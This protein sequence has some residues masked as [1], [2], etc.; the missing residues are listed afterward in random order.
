MK[1]LQFAVAGILLAGCTPEEFHAADLPR[2][3]P[4]RVKKLE[5]GK[6]PWIVDGKALLPIVRKGKPKDDNWVYW[7]RFTINSAGWLRSA[8]KE[9]TGVEPPLVRVADGEPLPEGPALFIGDEFAKAAGIE[10]PDRKQHEFRVVSKNGSIYFCGREDYAVYDFGER[11]LGIRQYW[12]TADGGRSVLKTPTI[13]LPELDYSDAPVY[14]KRDFWPYEYK[15]DWF[16]V[17]KG[18]NCHRPVFHCH[19]PHAWHTDTNFNYKVTRPEIFELTRDGR[20]AASPMLCYSNTKTFETYIERMEMELAGGPKSGLMDG[21][22]KTITIQQWDANID[23]QCED[24]KRNYDE[25]LGLSGN[26]S[27]LFYAFV[28]KVSDYVAEHHPEMMVMIAP[29][30]NTCDVP[31]GLTFPAKNVEALVCAM[32][33]FAM[34][35]EPSVREHE[36]DLVLAWEKACGRPVTVCQYSC[37]PA[38][39]CSAPF[40]FGHLANDYFRRMHGHIVG[41]FGNGPYPEN[42]LVLSAYVWV[43]S[44]WNFDFDVEKAYDVFAERMFGAGAAA[45]R[46]VIAMQERGWMRKWPVAQV[47]A[48]SIHK[49]SYPRAEV[50]EMERLFAEAKAACAGDELSLKRI[51]WYEKG[52]TEFFKESADFASGTA[53][54]PTLIQKVASDPI[55]DGKLDDA[56]W[57]A[58]KVYP[59]VAAKNATNEVRFATDVRMVWTPNGVSIGYRGDEPHASDKEYVK[60][61]RAK[62]DFA[63]HDT[64]LDFTGAGNGGYHQIYAH[65][66]GTTEFYTHGPS[67]DGKGVKTAWHFGEKEVCLEIFIPAATI[68]AVEGAQYPSGTSADGKFWLGNLHRE[69]CCGANLPKAERREERPYENTRRY[70]RGSIWGKDPAAFGKLQF[71]E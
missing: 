61:C 14:A 11:V 34:L 39:Y 1:L 59:L 8:V 3:K 64:F 52:F 21:P 12:A 51:A 26:A 10:V 23:C 70:T 60:K 66:N 18:G 47:A 49:I 7:S 71:V 29:Y 50:E 46:R 67:W 5:F 36:I 9:M 40:V 15:H 16:Y 65:D 6:I 53:L 31:E 68:R 30:M 28:R 19:V 24:C 17:W 55:I 32:P 38:D 54:E 48:K 37:W 22:T 20:R 4:E 58:A 45:M 27:R 43:R 13:I 57:K 63:R 2:L 56:A 42:R 44:M 25:K 33:G 35:K 69:R 62:D 41:S